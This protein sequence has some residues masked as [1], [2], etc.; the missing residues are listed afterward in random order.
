MSTY[1]G[2]VIVPNVKGHASG[3]GRVSF[4]EGSVVLSLIHI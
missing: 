2:L 4:R 3:F 1:E